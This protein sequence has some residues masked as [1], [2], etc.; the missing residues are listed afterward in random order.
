MTTFNVFKTHSDL[1]I[2]TLNKASIY[3]QSMNFT[4]KQENKTRKR[5]RNC[6][7]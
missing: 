6:V 1:L 2:L 7:Q 3:C 5:A 4:E